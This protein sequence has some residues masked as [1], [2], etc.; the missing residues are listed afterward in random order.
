M[1]DNDDSEKLCLSGSYK[2]TVSPQSVCIHDPVDGG[3]VQLWRL[4][5]LKRFRLAEDN[6]PGDAERILMIEA[7]V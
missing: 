7:G 2:L 6:L 1:I 3:T 5:T 4:N